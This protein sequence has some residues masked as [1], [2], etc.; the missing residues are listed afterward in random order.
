M[1][2]ICASNILNELKSISL[3][4]ST[5]ECNSKEKKLCEAIFSVIRK[6]EEAVISDVIE[7]EELVE[8]PSEFEDQA[9]EAYEPL[10]NNITNE[11]FE[12]DYMKKVIDFVD[13]GR[14]SFTSIQHRF[15][16]VKDQRYISRFR[17]YLTNLGTAREKYI[18]IANYVWEKFKLS[19][20]Q[21]RAV[22]DIDLRRW[23]LEKGRELEL[24]S[25]KASTWWVNSFKKNNRIVSRRVTKFVSF[26]HIETV[27]EIE[28][29][30]AILHVQLQN[31]VYPKFTHDQIFNT[32]QTGY[33]YEMTRDRTMDLIGARQVHVQVMNTFAT[34][35][36][37]TIQ[38]LVSMDGKLLPKLMIVLQEKDGQFGP[39]VQR[40][41]QKPPNVFLTCSRSGKVDTNILKQWTENCFAPFVNKQACLI[42]DSF[43]SHRNREL[44]L[45]PDKDIDVRIIPPG[46]TSIMQPLDVFFFRQWK[47]FTKRF[48]DRVL[49][50]GL[51]I[52]LHERNVII[53]L[54]AL[55]HNQFR[56]PRFSAMIK[57]AW[58]K[59]G[60]PVEVEMFDHPDNV[61][62]DTL[63]ETCSLTNCK[64]SSFILCSWC[65][66][67]FCLFHFIRP[68]HF[69]PEN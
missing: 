1:E 59:S 10:V 41:L 8:D 24:A 6:F 67:H 48:T 13:S 15:R 42:V 20:E 17:S 9:V 57:Y 51:D 65:Q 53:S 7:E 36:S 68:P 50:D 66:K 55:I 47:S 64:S 45:I 69:H 3:P 2:R 40:A 52:P 19:R 30:A 34:S 39:Q 56:S 63:L 60:F 5:R 22:H 29:S 49:I 46:A 18:K 43:S 33:N 23:A 14:H 38:P 21:H 61:I 44:F 37:Y 31:D 62:F 58:K 35:H 27:E 54:H 4:L 16:R 25:F 26:R 28:N 11:F 32:D 12:Y